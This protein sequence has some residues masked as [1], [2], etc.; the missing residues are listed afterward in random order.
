MDLLLPRATVDTP[1]AFLGPYGR[2]GMWAR[3]GRKGAQPPVVQ[4]VVVELLQWLPV[5]TMRAT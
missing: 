4:V 1:P 3:R 5:S 2:K